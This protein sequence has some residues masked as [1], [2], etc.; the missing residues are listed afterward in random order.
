MCVCVC[1]CVRE[2][3]RES[4]CVCVC[5]YVRVRF[6]KKK[7]KKALNSD[8]LFNMMKEATL[9]RKNTSWA[10]SEGLWGN[11][12][13]IALAPGFVMLQLEILISYVAG[14]NF[15]FRCDERGVRKG[16][17]KKQS[18]VWSLEVWGLPRLVD[19]SWRQMKKLNYFDKNYLWIASD[20]IA[21]DLDPLS[22][23]FPGGEGRGGR[24]VA[25]RP[26]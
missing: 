22:G 18:V 20:C 9:W 21:I 3:K 12:A 13:W 4:E 2:R 19:F 26:P 7:K 14:P 10:G 24:G 8:I 5:V 11:E 17:L 6:T 16:C 25:H 15:Q 23:K 1:V